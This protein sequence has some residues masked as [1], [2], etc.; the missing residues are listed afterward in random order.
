MVRDRLLTD[1]SSPRHKKGGI[2]DTCEHP[3]VTEIDIKIKGFEHPIICDDCNVVFECEHE[4]EL[5]DDNRLYC[6]VCDYEK[7]DE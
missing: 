3:F 1:S 7:E 6:W 5:T 4:Y 2:V